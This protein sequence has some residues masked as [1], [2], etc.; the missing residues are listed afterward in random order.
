MA[1][2]MRMPGVLA[3]A[4]EAILSK[5]IVQ[6]GVAFKIGEPLAEVETEKAIVEIPAEKDGV[7]GKHLVSEGKMAK[8]G[9]PIVV[10]LEPGE[11]T[12]A[13]AK[14]LN[15]STDE[16]VIPNL[17][18]KSESI[19]V[20]EDLAPENKRTFVSP[21]A[22]KLAREAGVEISSIR[23]SGPDGRIV[24][25][26]V[27]SAI[28]SQNSQKPTNQVN[29]EI[30][31]IPHSAMRKA[32]A[33]RLTESKSKVPHFYLN[34]ELVADDFLNLRKKINEWASAK[35][36]VTDLLLKTVAAAFGDVPNANLVWT[37]EASYLHK[38][39]DISVAVATENGLITPVVRQVNKLSIEELSHTSLD[40]INRARS[41]KLKQAE[42]EGGTFSITNLGMYGIDS[43]SA[44]LNPPQS[45]ILAVG[46]AK[47]KPIVV[48]NQ[49]KIADVIKF[50]L[51]VDHRVVD[52]ALAAE[53]MQA[54][55]KRFENPMWIAI[56]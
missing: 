11:G 43:F 48:E 16:N 36:S 19:K 26:D 55:S 18:K 46:A 10:I 25:R 12:D 21:I 27:E 56:S 3:D 47:R 13:I 20:E 31:A 29:G 32:I 1:E 5:W 34:S 44:I 15:V 53:W 6:E 23:G 30:I 24:R 41:G 39:V 33:R 4:T 52:G 2:L 49:V 45:M 7:L 38:D 42:I 22:R 17:D 37:N 40:L 50:T 35:V 9:E 28:Q 51:S 14:V 54:F 8:V